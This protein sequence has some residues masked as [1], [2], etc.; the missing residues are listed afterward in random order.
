MI[1]QNFFLDLCVK[2][3]HEYESSGKSLK[4]F[5]KRVCVVCLKEQNR[6]QK[7]RTGNKYRMTEVECCVCGKKFQKAIVQTK[8]RP[9][10]CCSKKCV[11]VRLRSHKTG[12]NRSKLE[13]WL[14]AQ[15]LHVFPNLAFVFND[16]K[17]INS[18]LDIYIPSLKLAFELNGP[19]HYEIVYGKECLEKVQ[20]NDKRKVQAC[21]AQEIS[22]CI[23][24]TSSI[25]YMKP[26]RCKWVL[27]YIVNIINDKL[28]ELH[29]K[30]PP[31]FSMIDNSFAC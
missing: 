12:T 6:A 1:Q 19:A 9:N 4:S 24:D 22:L 17:Q 8:I 30:K 31:Y 25:K 27:D 29:Y 18:E 20:N 2:D 28:E 14:E 5:S 10:H 13:V 26:S 23:I 21:I 7:Q 15:L 3:G 11:I 16:R